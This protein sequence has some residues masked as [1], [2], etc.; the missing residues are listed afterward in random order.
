MNKLDRYNDKRDFDTTPEPLGEAALAGG[1]QASFVVQKHDASSLHFD[2]RLEWDGVLLSWAVTKGPSDDPSEKRLAVRTEDHPVAYGSFEG[3]IPEDEY[4]GG[5]VMLWDSGA[6]EPLHDVA[7]GLKEG[8]L[9]FRLHGARM[10]GGWVL[11]KMG[12]GKGD[13]DPHLLAVDGIAAL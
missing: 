13:R 9:H 10:E 11:V 6:W 4:G 3:T 7:K 8:K 1:T 5:T 2:F 12:G